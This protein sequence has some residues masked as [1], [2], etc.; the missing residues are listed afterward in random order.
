M[1]FADLLEAAD[2]AARE[3]LGEDVTYTPGV[4][5]AETVRGIFDAAYTK[6]DAGHAG[7][8][9]TVPAVFLRIEDLPSDPNDDTDCRI[10]AG[11]TVYKVREAEPDGQG[12][13]V[14]FLQR[15]A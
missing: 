1:S 8:S 3:T 4:G 13:V 12:G 5:G 6:M 10:T 7:V 2:D 11:G 15:A 9:A 14:C